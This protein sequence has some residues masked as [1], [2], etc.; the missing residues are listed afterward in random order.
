MKRIVRLT[1]NMLPITIGKYST[2]GTTHTEAM[3][4]A[5]RRP[6]NNFW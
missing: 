5:S 4:R 3:Q 6:V 1:H 2:A